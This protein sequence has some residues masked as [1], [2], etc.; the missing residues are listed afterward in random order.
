MLEK[1]VLCAGQNNASSRPCCQRQ[2]SA[3]VIETNIEA[4]N[5]LL[6]HWWIQSSQLV[7]VSADQWFYSFLLCN[8]YLF[9]INPNICLM[10]RDLAIQHISTAA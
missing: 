6:T 3:G 1:V 2:A 7:I 8:C 10:T 5:N 9:F 4:I